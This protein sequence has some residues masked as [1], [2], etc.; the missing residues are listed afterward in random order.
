LIFRMNKNI[1]QAVFRLT[2]P[3]RAN[4]ASHDNSRSISKNIKMRLLRFLLEKGSIH[5]LNIM[6]NVSS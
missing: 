3:V 6:F 5:L 1:E 4:R 2:T